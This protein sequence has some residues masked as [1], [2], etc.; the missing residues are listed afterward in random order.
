MYYPYFVTYML[1]GLAISLVVF[2]WA[3]H[4]GQFRD[5]ERARFL[6]LQGEPE[7]VPAKSSAMS[8]IETCALVFLACA[9]FLAVVAVL[10]FALL[11][12]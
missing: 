11:R 12:A 1:I 6:P 9:A 10:A 8:R 7:T 2:L 3:L 5:Q 4:H